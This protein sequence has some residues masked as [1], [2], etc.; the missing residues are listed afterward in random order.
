MALGRMTQF[1]AVHL[2][3]RLLCTGSAPCSFFSS[4]LRLAGVGCSGCSVARALPQQ[5][6]C[7][8]RPWRTRRRLTKT[9]KTDEQ[10]N[11][12]TDELQNDLPIARFARFAHQ[13]VRQLQSSQFG[14]LFVQPHRG[15]ETPFQA[16]LL[17]WI[18]SR[19]LDLVQVDVS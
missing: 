4:A 13:R 3:L 15:A 12:R 19:S 9:S 6:I 10:Q 16:E 11:C 7:R 2:A 14:L 1:S 18:S 8:Q 17:A 5:R